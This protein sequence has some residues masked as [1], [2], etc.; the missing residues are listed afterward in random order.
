MGRY[1]EAATCRSHDNKRKKTPKIPLDEIPNKLYNACDVDEVA[2]EA[3]QVWNHG[4]FTIVFTSFWAHPLQARTRNSYKI[5]D[6][7][8]ASQIFLLEQLCYGLVLNKSREINGEASTNRGSSRQP[9]RCK[10]GGRAGGCR[11]AA[12]EGMEERSTTIQDRTKEHTRTP[13]HCASTGSG[14][15]PTSNAIFSA[16]KLHPFPNIWNTWHFLRIGDSVNWG[17]VR[18][19]LR[20]N[21]KI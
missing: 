14:A 4:S 19:S 11:Y 7:Q 3:R 8:W 9:T 21:L 5:M 13:R 20:D 2:S 15:V 17:W 12:R 16:K 18:L 1:C 6:M 10:P